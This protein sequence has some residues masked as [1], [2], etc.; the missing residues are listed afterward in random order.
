MACTLA[1]TKRR[2]ATTAWGSQNA[3]YV[4]ARA[5]M[6]ACVCVCVCVRSSVAFFT[7]I[8]AW[9]KYRDWYLVTDTKNFMSTDETVLTQL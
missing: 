6:R 4:S 5:R 1:R 2:Q 3:V 9:P 8:P 7:E